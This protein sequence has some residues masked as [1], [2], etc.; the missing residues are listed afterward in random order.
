M[1]NFSD[2]NAVLLMKSLHDTSRFLN[3]SPLLIDTHTDES[4][5]PAST[6]VKKD[7]W[8][9]VGTEPEDSW[10]KSQENTV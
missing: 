7:I 2:S 4:I 5:T 3:L 9:V 8:F 6:K 10:E 1:E